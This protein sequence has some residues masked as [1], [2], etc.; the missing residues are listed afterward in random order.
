MCCSSYLLVH[1]YPVTP[2][3]TK[4]KKIVALGTR[5]GVV[6]VRVPSDDRRLVTIERRRGRRG[7]PPQARGLRGIVVASL[8]VAHGQREVGPGPQI[9]P[10]QDPG[11]GAGE[12]VEHLPLG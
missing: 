12:H 8:S 4:P 9:D 3:N 11:S 7:S 5:E 1:S 6:P 2:R 10:G